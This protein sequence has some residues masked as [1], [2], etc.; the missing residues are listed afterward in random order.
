[1]KIQGGYVNLWRNGSTVAFNYGVRFT[2]VKNYTYNS[3]AA[4][5]DG[6]PYYAMKSKGSTHSDSGTWLYATSSSSTIKKYTA[7]SADFYYSTTVDGV[8]GGEITVTVG[9]A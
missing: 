3:I 2:T 6:T 7:E 1:M 4:I 9:T 8:G 5:I